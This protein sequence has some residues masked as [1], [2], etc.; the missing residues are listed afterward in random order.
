MKAVVRKH[1]G[2][3]ENIEI[4]DVNTPT[5]KSEEALVKV[6]FT[7]VNRTDQGVITGLPYVFRFFTGLRKPTYNILGTDFVGE[8]VEIGKDHQTYKIGDF[9][10]GFNDQGWP[11]QAEFTVINKN[12]CTSLCPPNVEL[13]RVV[14]SAEGFHWA[15][16]FLNKVELLPGK[17]AF[18]YGATGA[19]GSAMIQILKNKGMYVVT[20]CKKE[21][22]DHVKYLN[23]DKV[24]DFENEDISE[25]NETFDYFF[26]AVGKKRFDFS[27]AILKQKGIYISSELGPGAENL[28]LPLL[29]FW[30]DQKVIFPFPSNIAK[31]LEVASKMINEKTF[32]P[33]IDRTFDINDAAEA[34]KYMMSQQK[35]GNVILKIAND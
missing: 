26:D 31:S 4:C 18:V 13:S 27:K 24:I 30:R 22:F 32:T 28:Y 6:H 12:I 2:G 16:N 23:A 21:H 5:L 14:A 8:V 9:V 1:Y 11:T 20:C 25:I 29:T 34:Y 19:I 33:L 17:S 7:T 3:H 10:W 35:L 15:L